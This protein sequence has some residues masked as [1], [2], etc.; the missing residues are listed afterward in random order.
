[1]ATYEEL[2]QSAEQIRTNELPES[3]TH[4][5]VGQHLKNQV[6]H[7][8][9]EGNGIKSLIEANKK[10]VDGKLAELDNKASSVGHVVC[11]T[12]ASIAAKTITVDGITEITDKLRLLVQ[13]NFAN[14]A[15]GTVTLNI[16]NLGAKTLYYNG[17]TV[18]AT[19][20]WETGEVVELYYANDAFLCFN[21][22]GGSGNGGNMILEWDTDVATTRK[23][24]KAKDRKAGMQISYLDPDNGW[25]NEQ[26]IS[27]LV[28]DAEWVKGSNWQNMT[29][30]HIENSIASQLDRGD[31]LYSYDNEDDPKQ[32]NTRLIVPTIQFPVGEINRVYF[33]NYENKDGAYVVAIN[34]TTNICTKKVILSWNDEEGCY[35]PEAAILINANEK[36]GF[37]KNEI[38]SIFMQ[39][40]SAV[41][42]DMVSSIEPNIGDEVN[43]QV[44]YQNYRLM[45]GINNYRIIRRVEEVK[46]EQ[47]EKLIEAEGKLTANLNV[48]SSTIEKT[49]ANLTITANTASSTKKAV[50]SVIKAL[51]GTTGDIE[52]EYSVDSNLSVTV[53][54]NV[55]EQKVSLTWRLPSAGTDFPF[56]NYLNKSVSFPQE[57]TSGYIQV[58]A[59]YSNGTGYVSGHTYYC[60][61]YIDVEEGSDLAFSSFSRID[62]SPNG[63]SGWYY[64]YKVIVGATPAT[65]YIQILSGKVTIRYAYA[66]DLTQY[67]S[68][69]NTNITKENVNQSLGQKKL[70]PGQDYTP[71]GKTTLTITRDE[72]CENIDYP[73]TEATVKGGDVL[74]IN[75][76]SVSFVATYQGYKI[77]EISADSKHTLNLHNVDRLL[78]TGDSYTESIYYIAGK[79]WTCQF[80]EMSDYSVEAYGWGGYTAQTLRQNFE[81]DLTRYNPI[82]PSRLGAT[83]TIIM[84]RANDG[85]DASNDSAFSEELDKLCTT[86]ENMG[87]KPIIASEFR[88]ARPQS[89]P[90]LIH[91]IARLHDTECWNI[92]PTCLWLGNKSASED[93]GLDKWFNGSHPAQRCGGIILENMR[94]FADARLPRPNSAIKIYRRRNQSSD[95][96]STKWEK[97]SSWKEIGIS[98][99]ALQDWTNWDDM[100]DNP[101]SQIPQESE[102][103]KLMNGETLSSGGEYLLEAIL[104]TNKTNCTK[105]S[106]TIEDTPSDIYAWDGKEWVSVMVNDNFSEYLIADKLSLKIISDTIVAPT[107]T[108]EGNFV[109]K[110]S[111]TYDIRKSGEELRSETQ[112]YLIASE[113]ASN[114]TNYP[115]SPQS[116]EQIAKLGSSYLTFGK[117][118]ANDNNGT[119]PDQTLRIVARW[120]PVDNTPEVTE[121]SLDRR[122]FKVEGVC[123]YGSSD[124]VWTQIGV[125][126]VGMAWQLIEIPLSI[127]N[128]RKFRI[129]ALDS[130]DIEIAIISQIRH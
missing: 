121:T 56:R 55:E 2:M 69:N 123:F 118:S 41:N 40:E 79:S 113:L 23:Q 108:W 80:S 52:E 30:A 126:D 110:I 60:C 24:V 76:G 13:M 51:G 90:N 77:P 91:S 62:G 82:P 127:T 98:H 1:M 48:L 27:N 50:D 12:S 15:I 19:N 14:T 122:R 78:L 66:L 57:K 11:Q 70:I 28:T 129:K 20:T 31:V 84:T 83:R 7:F 37:V 125:Y 33:Y 10:E 61:I 18:S 16:N 114:I 68:N 128:T 119:L 67:N 117:E 73:T 105:I 75:Q 112:A 63:G 64:G 99:S 116:V 29:P 43:L 130:E 81:Q 94:A 124:E 86:L 106:L 46:K 65:P 97:I 104:P 21:A 32:L 3:N 42:A 53:G 93:S 109:E 4:E 34:N 54:D 87:I 74:S 45:Y 25:V 9:K 38:S 72:A 39:V 95:L 96:I 92:Y 58:Y 36:Y 85:K 49:N 35:I 101:T 26:Y 120:N 59:N 47:E 115:I 100:S 89:S 6:E 17:A 71:S 111:H 44:A 22:K 102:Y 8:N 107:F 88:D 103:G 5:L